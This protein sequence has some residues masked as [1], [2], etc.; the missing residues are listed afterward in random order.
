MSVRVFD[1]TAIKQALIGEEVWIGPIWNG[2]FLVAKEEK[3]ELAFT[4]PT[5]GAVLWMDSFVIPVGAENV[6]NAYAFINYMLRPEVAARCIEEYKYSSPNM[7]AIEQLPAEMR[8]NR[9]LVPGPAELK[10]AEFTTGIG[11]APGEYEKYWEQ[12]KTMQ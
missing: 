2:D 9:V 7:K 3:P 10:N 8:E 5:E 12:I 11:D 1:V 6:E 4:F